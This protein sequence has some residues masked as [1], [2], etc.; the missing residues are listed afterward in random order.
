MSYINIMF[1][2]G[3]YLKCSISRTPE[4]TFHV[5]RGNRESS[6]IDLYT[7]MISLETGAGEQIRGGISARLYD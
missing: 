1:E 4:L 3:V 6:P 2:S 5:L 7:E